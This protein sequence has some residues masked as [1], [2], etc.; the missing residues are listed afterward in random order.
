[1]T[2]D[3]INIAIK[4]VIAVLSVSITTYIIPWLKSKIEVER[5]SE[6]LA[7]IE[8]CVEAAEKI[9]STE[10]WRDK[11]QYVYAMAIQ[12]LDSIGLHLSEEEVDALIEGFVKAVK[13]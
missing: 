3:I 1:M 6:L 4:I 2:N 8:K 5:Y 12:K 11:K 7:F 10:E 13:G 9:Y